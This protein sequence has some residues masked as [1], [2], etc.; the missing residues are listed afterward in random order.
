MDRGLTAIRSIP[1]S[2]R[3]PTA[4]LLWDRGTEAAEGDYRRRIRLLEATL[5]PRPGWAWVGLRRVPDP[6]RYGVA[7]VHGDRVGSIE[8]KPKR[9]TSDYAVIEAYAYPPNVFE[10]VR[11]LKPS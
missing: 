4:R 6:G 7:E 1:R 2:L 3:L 8:E 9:P 5:G 10:V 11:P